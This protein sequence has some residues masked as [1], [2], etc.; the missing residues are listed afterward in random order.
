MPKN[1]PFASHSLPEYGAE[2][3]PLSPFQKAKQV[4]DE[5]MGEPSARAANWRFFALAVTGLFVAQSGLEY[6]RE[7]NRPLPA[8]AVPVDSKGMAVNRPAFMEDARYVP[9]RTQ[10]AADIANWIMLVRGRPADGFT[11]RQNLLTAEAFMDGD[12]IA[13]FN[14]YKEKFDP[15]QN[16][17][18]SRDQSSKITTVITGPEENPDPSIMTFPEVVPLEGN[19]YQ[20]RWREVKWEY[21]T[22]SKPYIMT[23]VIRAKG[24]GQTNPKKMMMNPAGTA[25]S[26][27][28]WRGSPVS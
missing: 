17:K 16:Y 21:G 5:R 4:W 13:L 14:A 23:A 6:Y 26:W 24:E 10:V 3:P 15:W 28:E 18:H 20:A 12:G 1:N 22:P 25:I 11:L 9:S 27:W 19:S 7:F 8:Y 2:K